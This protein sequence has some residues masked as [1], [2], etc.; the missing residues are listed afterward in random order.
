MTIFLELFFASAGVSLALYASYSFI[1][2]H[3]YRAKDTKKNDFSDSSITKNQ[4]IDQTS[5]SRESIIYRDIINMHQ[6]K[7]CQDISA[8]QEN[9]SSNLFGEASN[10]KFS[11]QKSD[12]IHD[13]IRKLTPS[14]ILKD[15]AE[16]KA[17]LANLSFRVDKLSIQREYLQKSSDRL[18]EFNQEIQDNHDENIGLLLKYQNLIS[19]AT[20]ES[21]AIDVQ[22]ETVKNMG[23][24]SLIEVERLETLFEVA[25]ESQNQQQLAFHVIEVGDERNDPYE[26]DV[27]YSGRP[28]V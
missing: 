13:P 8:L 21:K 28:S 12:N 1:K 14:I 19:E 27:D 18:A 20:D 16:K 5:Y 9:A 24:Q 17:K 15:L 6:A 7:S 2:R 25:Q 11:L 22:L 26:Q 3:V 4:K 10:C 23:T